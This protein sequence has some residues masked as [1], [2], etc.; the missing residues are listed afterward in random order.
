[1]I[2]E[3]L[4]KE[5]DAKVRDI[6]VDIFDYPHIPYWFTI[7]QAVKILKASYQGKEKTTYPLGILVFDERYNLLGTLDPVDILK[8]KDTGV[9]SPFLHADELKGYGET[10]VSEVM[11]SVKC[12]VGPDDPIT[13]AAQL[14][15]FYDLLLLP[16]LEG[17]K[18]IGL[19]I[20][21]EVFE[22]L[23]AELLEQ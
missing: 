13:K 21:T 23:S 11:V 6:I 5:S 16:V 2:E 12:F 8:G 9:S 10:P 14:M 3:F 19:A 18:L 1:M 22:K 4:K 20:F 15:I 17:Q 7:K